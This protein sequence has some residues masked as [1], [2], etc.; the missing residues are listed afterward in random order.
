MNIFN[1]LND[2]MKQAATKGLGGTC[3]DVSEAAPSRIEDVRQAFAETGRIIVWSGG[4]DT[5]IY[6]DSQTN[7]LFRAWHDLMH[8][9]IGAGFDL[10]G[11][12]RTALSQMSQVGTLLAQIIR[13]EVIQQAVYYFETG[14]FI[15]DQ[16]LWTENQL[17][18]LRSN[19][20]G[21]K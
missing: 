16:R 1:G 13:I 12:T 9:R 6:Q 19:G 10:Q 4:S 11:E 14:G 15:A 21:S 7:F 2:S 20:I 3:F 8:V 18:T 5:T 17:N